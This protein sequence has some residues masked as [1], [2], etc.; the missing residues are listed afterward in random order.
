MVSAELWLKVSIEQNS[1]GLTLIVKFFN[2]IDLMKI[3]PYLVQWHVTIE[4]WR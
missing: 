1:L 3:I 4:H 2:L